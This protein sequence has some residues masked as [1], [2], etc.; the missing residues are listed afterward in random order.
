MISNPTKRALDLVWQAQEELWKPAPDYD[1][2]VDLGRRAIQD[3]TLPRHRS[4]AYLV[5]AKAHEGLCNWRLAFTC[6]SLCREL[7]P[8][9]WTAEMKARIELMG[10]AC[11]E[12]DD[13]NQNFY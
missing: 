12:Y 5:L 2:A 4:N 8:E 7:Y 1:R 6:W 3:L 10:E 13:T 9:G 11:K